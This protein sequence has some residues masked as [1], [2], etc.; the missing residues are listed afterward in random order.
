MISLVRFIYMRETNSI[1]DFNYYNGLE[2]EYTFDN[3]SFHL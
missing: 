2:H 1:I 3:T